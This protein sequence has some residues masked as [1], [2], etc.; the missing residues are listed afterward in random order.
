MTRLARHESPA[1]GICSRSF[2]A[3]T[4]V[5]R[6]R[7]SHAPQPW[8]KVW[9]LK[10][11]LQGMANPRF[12][13]TRRVSS[14]RASSPC[15]EQGGD[16]KRLTHPV[17]DGR[18]KPVLQGQDR[19]LTAVG[20]ATTTTHGHASRAVF[21]DLLAEMLEGVGWCPSRARLPTPPP[22]SSPSASLLAPSGLRAIVTRG[23]LGLARDSLQLGPLDTGTLVLRRCRSLASVVRSAGF[24]VLRWRRQSGPLRGTVRLRPLRVAAA[25]SRRRRSPL[26][27]LR[28]LRSF[29]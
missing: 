8:V 11:T 7:I 17:P 13:S 24:A 2:N 27:R 1:R 21:L 6:S 23:P 25:H 16:V 18:E 14:R 28:R 19:S 5:E 26:P 9:I 4:S 10:P 12:A 29:A 22:V 15:D 3:F 20:P